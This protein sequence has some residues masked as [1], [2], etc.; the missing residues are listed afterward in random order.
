MP[1]A[2]ENL[3]ASN[4]QT[5]EFGANDWLIDEMYQAYRENPDSVDPRW[6]QFFAERAAAPA[7]GAAVRAE[8]PPGPAP[9]AKSET[10]PPQPAASTPK[11]T[12]PGSSPQPPASGRWVAR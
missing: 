10:T 7:N 11:P 5:D 8:A 6:Q 1:L 2:P 3:T 12:P 9:T 4:E